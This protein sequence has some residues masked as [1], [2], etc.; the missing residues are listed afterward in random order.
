MATRIKATPNMVKYYVAFIGQ[1]KGGGI[2][3]GNDTI[4]LFEPITAES[5]EAI[6]D[7]IGIRRGLN[8]IT[9]LNL[10]EISED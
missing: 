3:F 5:M 8:Q 2:I 10:M 7:Y 1:D 6:R 9:I 4:K